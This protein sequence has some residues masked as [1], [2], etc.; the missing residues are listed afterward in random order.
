MPLDEA[1]EDYLASL[2]TVAR[3]ADYLAINVSSPNTPGLRSLQDAGTLAELISA[4]V[5]RGMAARRRRPASADLRQGG[6]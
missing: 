6:A 1:A 5:N 2:R 4:L 3:Y